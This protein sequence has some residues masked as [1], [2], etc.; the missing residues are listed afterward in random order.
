[1]RRRPNC[2]PDGQYMGRG[3]CDSCYWRAHHRGTLIDHGRVNRTREELLEDYRL[4]RSEGFSRSQIADRLG[5]TRDAVDKAISRARRAG[6]EV[7]A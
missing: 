2:H 4:L 5:V 1:M 3:L 6:I 7:A